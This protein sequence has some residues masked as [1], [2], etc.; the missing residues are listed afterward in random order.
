MDRRIEK[1]KWPAQKL[2]IYIGIPILIL[3]G[4]GALMR[5]A[6][7][8]R[9]RVQKDRLTISPVSEGM[10]QEFTPING[11]VMALKSVYVTAIEGGQVE[12]LYREGGELVEKGDLIIKLSNPGLEMNYMNLQTNLLE[13]ADQLRNTRITMENTALALKDQLIQSNYQILDLGQQYERSKLLYEDS[14]MAEADFLTIKNNYQ[15]QIRRKKLLMERIRKDSVLRSQQMGQVQNSLSLVGRNLQAIQSNLDNL[16]VR[17]P[18]NGLLSSIPVELGQT[19]TQGQNLGQVDILGGYKVRVAIDEHFISRIVLGLKGIFPFAG[20]DHE[21][22]I[23]KIYPA[24]TNGSFEVDM[25]FIGGAPEGIKRGQNLQIRLALSDETKAVMVPL[26]GFYQS[27]GG[28]YIFVLDVNE[29][30]AVKREIK[31]GRKSHKHYEVLT[32]LN[33]GEKVVTSS[34]DLYPKADQLVFQ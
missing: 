31:I 27:T 4:L 13:Q 18:V 1:K 15:Y 24:V 28:N 26:G 22:V 7:T 30:T 5:N 3:G 16:T 32:G 20:K 11:T 12:I 34:Y 23:K 9:Y 29:E 14:I 25:E 21:L 17:A 8:N 2:L 33:A 19:I 6:G 10:F